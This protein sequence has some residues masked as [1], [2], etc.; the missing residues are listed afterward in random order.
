MGKQ[1]R[2]RIELVAREQPDIALYVQ[3]LLI[4]AR[5]PLRPASVEPSGPGDTA[6]ATAA[7]E[8]PSR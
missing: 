7:K 4:T 8:V 1:K 5:E 2:I 6:E 3:A